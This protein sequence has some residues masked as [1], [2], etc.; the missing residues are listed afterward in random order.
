[1]EGAGVAFRRVTSN[2]DDGG[3]PSRRKPKGHKPAP[4]NN[5]N[6]RNDNNPRSDNN[7]RGDGRPQFHGVTGERYKPAYQTSTPLT[8][9]R[10]MIFR[11]IRNHPDLKYPRPLEIC[12]IEKEEKFCEFHDCKGHDTRECLHSRDELERL[13][14]LRKL[15]QF[16]RKRVEDR[17]VKVLLPLP[18]PQMAKSKSTRLTYPGTNKINCSLVGSAPPFQNR[19]LLKWYRAHPLLNYGRLYNR[20]SPLLLGLALL[21]SDATSRP[22]PK[23]DPAV[24]I[25]SR[26]FV[27]LLTSSLSLVLLSQMMTWCCTSLEALEFWT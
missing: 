8:L 26:R 24:R 18:L 27:P 19:S 3:E 2:F 16:V 13:V 11:R 25:T 7:H 20:L 22:P 21:S 12:E 14:R 9:S 23:A 6:P 10:D 15:L 4:R 1:M 5:K 17:P